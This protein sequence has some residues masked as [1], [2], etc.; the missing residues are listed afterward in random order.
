MEYHRMAINSLL[1]S[2]QQE[3]LKHKIKT[4]KNTEAWGLE[5]NSLEYR[6]SKTIKGKIDELTTYE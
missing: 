6:R 2:L 4:E 1:S 3:R 5:R